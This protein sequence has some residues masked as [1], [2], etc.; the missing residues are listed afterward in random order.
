MTNSVMALFQYEEEVVQAARELRKSG[1]ENL[2]LM[3]PIPLHDAEVAL[4]LDKSPV[5]R[6]SLIGAIVGCIFGFALASASALVFIL[7]T[8]GRAII[9]VPPFL[10][11]SYEMTI[12]MG[13]L[14]TLIGFF[15][16]SRLPAWTDAAYREESSVDRFSL[17]V[18]VGA[19]GDREAAEKIIREAGAEE[20]TEED[21]R[22]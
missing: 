5:R 17:V 19:D 8:G 16:I 20:V 11:I 13:V 4:G 18:D 14:A 21:K 9:T 1:F 15:V 12:L 7:P 3:S 2:S 10:I 22:L 6:F